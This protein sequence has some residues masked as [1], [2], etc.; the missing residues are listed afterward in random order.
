MDRNTGS[1]DTS[2]N[3]ERTG[4]AA[5]TAMLSLNRPGVQA[6]TP[7]TVNTTRHP[8]STGG[9]RVRG[10][11][12]KRGARPR[13][14]R[15]PRCAGGTGASHGGNHPPRDQHH[16]A[17]ESQPVNLTARARHGKERE[18]G[19][20]PSVPDGAG[21]RGQST[22]RPPPS[23]KQR[24]PAWSQPNRRPAPFPVVQVRLFPDHDEELRPRAVLFPEAR[25]GDG[26]GYVSQARLLSGIRR[27]SA[28]ASWRNRLPYRPPWTTPMGGPM[29][30]A[31]PVCTR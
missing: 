18:S 11:H 30:C 27:E 19:A 6:T 7:S 23:R 9:A 14:G 21:W 3:V 16:R 31:S 22:Y 4:E 10:Q 13:G 20:A 24:T 1:E 5:K 15:K 8:T 28:V 2:S 25:H 12:R 17:A 29:S 26:P